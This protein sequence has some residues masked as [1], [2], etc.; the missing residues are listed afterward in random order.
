MLFKDTCAVFTTPRTFKNETFERVNYPIAWLNC[1]RLSLKPRNSCAFESSLLV[2]AYSWFRS[3]KLENS[4]VSLGGGDHHRN[5][6]SRF[7]SGTAE[8]PN[9]ERFPSRQ[10]YFNISNWRYLVLGLGLWKLEAEENVLGSV[11]LY[12]VL[13]PRFVLRSTAEVW[14]WAGHRVQLRHLAADVLQPITSIC[15]FKPI[16]NPTYSTYM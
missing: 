7:R 3:Q 4:W 2:H 13:K 9:P 10:K 1:V 15:K 6:H 12:V 16:Q 11:K 5:Y 8:S 14:P